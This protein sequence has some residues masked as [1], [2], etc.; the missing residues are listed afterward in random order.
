M[1]EFTSVLRARTMI[2]ARIAEAALQ[3]AGIA[4]VVENFTS[5]PYDGLWV[6]QRGYG[7]ILV[8]PEDAERARQI[9]AEALAAAPLLE[10]EAASADDEAPDETEEPEEP[11]E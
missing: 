10:D 2:E 9:I 4:C 11:Q 8:Q 6:L 3:D 1:A 5:D 7:R